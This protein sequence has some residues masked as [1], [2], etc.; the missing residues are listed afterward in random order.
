MDGRPA[1][2]LQPKLPRPRR[3]LRPASLPRLPW[4]LVPARMRLIAGMSMKQHPSPSLPQAGA[5]I[6][7][8]EILEDDLRLL[9]PQY[10]TLPGVD[11][12]LASPLCPQTPH[13]PTT[14]I[15]TGMP[16]SQGFPRPPTP[17]QHHPQELRHRLSSAV[18]PSL[19]HQHP[20]LRYDRHMLFPAEGA[21]AVTEQAP[22]PYHPAGGKPL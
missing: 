6:L 13:R 16:P 11:P 7:E 15:A 4:M 17:R 2:L 22:D 1:S 5:A 14:P 10:S 19:R 8:G 9:R 18:L 20:S 12:A 3:R 21:P